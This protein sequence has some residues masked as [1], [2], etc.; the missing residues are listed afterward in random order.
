MEILIREGTS[1]CTTEF[2]L[3]DFMSGFLFELYQQKWRRF[4]WYM[5][6]VLRAI[7]VALV[8]AVMYLCVQ[9]KGEGMAKHQFFMCKL[10]IGLIAVFVAGELFLGH[11]YALNFKSGVPV[12][13][14]VR[15]TWRWMRS[16]A[17][18]T[19]LRACAVLVIAVAVYMLTDISVDIPSEIS[20]V[21]GGR[22]LRSR[23]HAREL[24]EAL[25]YTEITEAQR[26]GAMFEY[27]TQSAKDASVQGTEPLIWLLMA[28]GMEISRARTTMT[29]KYAPLTTI[30]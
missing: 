15:R 17:I 4:G 23:F 21:D 19:N 6:G 9:L 16:F 7:D 24:T 3:D 18:E 11:L 2:L 14:L 28:L 22:R 20:S 1:L 10:L 30:A 5:H 13:E 12:L 8:A 27:A 26:T 29:F 25:D